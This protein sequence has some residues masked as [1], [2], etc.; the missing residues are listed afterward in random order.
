MSLSCDNVPS[1]R[2]FIRRDGRYYLI[3]EPQ[4]DLL[5]DHVVVTRRGSQYSRLGGSKTYCGAD[6]SDLDEVIARIVKTRIQ[7]G[8]TEVPA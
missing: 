4:R 5:G 2:L 7:H 3:A 8:Y 6:P 1:M